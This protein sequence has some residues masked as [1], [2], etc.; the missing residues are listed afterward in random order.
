MTDGFRASAA[1]DARPPLRPFASG[2]RYPPRMPESP[3]AAIGIDVGGH[4]VKAALIAAD[5]TLLDFQRR[6]I[7]GLGERGID[8]IEERIRSLV[9][10]LRSDD[11]PIGVGVPGFFDRRQGLLR[12]SPNLPDWQDVPVAARLTK[13]LGAP[14]VAENDANCA[15]LGEAFAGAARGLHNVVLLTLGT[16]VGTGLL[17]EGRLVR[18][19]NGAAGEGGHI[20]LYAGGRKCGDGL[21]GC[22][23]TYVSGP[24]LVKTAKEAW[25]EEGR[26]GRCPANTAEDVFRAEVEHGGAAPDLWASRGIERFALDLAAGLV[27]F[28][29][30]LSPEAIVIGGGLS[31]ALPRFAPTCEGELRRRAIPACLGDVLP[32]RAAALGQAAGAVG[33]A[34]LALGFGT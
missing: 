32:L 9:R 4:G 26:E 3:P 27:P 14:V 5:G 12:S 31:V 11:V 2:P 16:G 24:G 10:E 19:A 30:L 1:P 13:L 21:R 15:L 34:A 8:A 17:V 18:G 20:P 33:A 7:A 28:V 23:E 29:H 25:D 22:L 6:D